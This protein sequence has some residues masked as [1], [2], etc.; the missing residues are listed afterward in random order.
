M[1]KAMSKWD[2]FHKFSGA[3]VNHENAS[4]LLTS[5]TIRALALG[6][7]MVLSS[8]SSG[9]EAA[10]NSISQYQYTGGNAQS[11]SYT[12]PKLF[13]ATTFKDVISNSKSGIYLD[14]YDKKDMIVLSFLD[15]N[16]AGDKI[17]D[18]ISGR[19]LSSQS[20]DAMVSA[21]GNRN[22]ET[23]NYSAN[24]SAPNASSGGLNTTFV[25]KTPM[26]PEDAISRR[27]G[28][29]DTY[30]QLFIVMHEIAHQK[31]VA[32]VDAPNLK[33]VDATQKMRTFNEL[34]SDFAALIMTSQ[35]M[36]KDGVN[37][38]DI[39]ILMGD[40]LKA[41]ALTEYNGYGQDDAEPLA[42]PTS[43][44][45]KYG[46]SLLENN[47]D[48]VHSMP[49]DKV[50]MVSAYVA[51]SV[52]EH[53]FRKDLGIHVDEPVGVMDR[54][55]QKIIGEAMQNPDVQLG[56]LNSTINSKLENVLAERVINEDV[57]EMMR[58]AASVAPKEYEYSFR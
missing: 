52:M 53:D 25:D 23:I 48:F 35:I 5:N 11:V 56:S 29:S 13:D 30:G 47:P 17:K 58:S 44:T 57:P 14:P 32:S 10:N 49:S 33:D 36:K 40:I 18:E 4:P 42:H 2:F 45:I 16:R 51:G 24:F 6:S 12:E 22:F 19:G 15:D 39:K 26:I 50:Q 38:S 31:S 27:N 34:K 46:L 9:V 43:T 55:G 54:R 20:Y 37:D 21:F 7:A 41:R 3:N 1:S 28:L 8:A